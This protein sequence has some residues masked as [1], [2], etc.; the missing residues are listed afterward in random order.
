MDE[1]LVARVLEKYNLSVATICAPQ[2]GYRNTS[3]PVSLQDGRTVNVVFYKREPQILQRIHAA[4]QT[5]NFLAGQG[6]PTRQ[7]L[8][9]I[10]RLHAGDYEKFAVL[11]TY[12]PGH[13][14][15]WEGYTMDHLKQL[16]AVMGKMHHTLQRAP[17][18][19]ANIVQE[20]Q[21][22]LQRMR[23]Y[24]VDSSVSAALQAKVGLRLRVDFDHFTQLLAMAHHLPDQQVLH[25][26]FVR[27]NI[28][29]DDSPT[30]LGILDF[31][32]TAYGPRVFDIARTLAF[33]LVDCKYKPEPKIRKYFLVS[34][35]NKRG[36]LPFKRPVISGADILEE[37]VSFFL[38]HDFYKFLRHNPYEHLGQNEHFIRTHDLLIARGLLA[39]VSPSDLLE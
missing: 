30:I 1:R 4:D 34:G 3:Y 11:Y 8:G 31:E 39:R 13:T 12:L 14:I 23:R 27:G 9:P 24:F 16:G 22:L 35:Y 18:V 15:P 36:P 17:R 26:D 37:L 33:L 28:L 7:T 29:F 38:L 21:A 6:L 25:M 10:I 19:S 2:K 32:K 5:S 20:C